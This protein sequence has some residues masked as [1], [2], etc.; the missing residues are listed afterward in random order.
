MSIR[1]IPVRVVGPGSQPNLADDALAYIDMPSDMQKFVAPVMPDPEEV[2]DLD[3][4]RDAVR[5]LREALKEFTVGAAP[6]LANLSA[7]DEDSRE[8]KGRSFPLLLGIQRRTTG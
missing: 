6:M 1:D 7:L 5:W 8:P 2:A 3:G 4:A